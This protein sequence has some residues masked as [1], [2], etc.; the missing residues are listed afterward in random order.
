MSLRSISLSSVL[1]CTGFLSNE[2]SAGCKDLVL[3]MQDQG[4]KHSDRELTMVLSCHGGSYEFPEATTVNIFEWKHGNFCHAHRV[5]GNVKYWKGHIGAGAAWSWGTTVSDFAKSSETVNNFVELAAGSGAGDGGAGGAGG[6]ASFNN[7]NTCVNKVSANTLNIG[8]AS[9]IAKSNAKSR[10]YQSSLLSADDWQNVCINNNLVGYQK[11]AGHASNTT[12]NN[13]T[14][15]S[16]DQTLK[17]IRANNNNK[18]VCVSD[19]DSN[20][21]NELNQLAKG[22][23]VNVDACNGD[24][25][26][27][28]TL[29]G[30]DGGNGGNGGNG[31]SPVFGIESGETDSAGNIE[32]DFDSTTL[33]VNFAIEFGQIERYCSEKKE[34]V[35]F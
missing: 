27:D 19:A 30:G 6:N 8:K 20:V 9:G 22:S 31:Y 10:C 29:V 16:C 17:G 2:L 4:A 1:F 5:C 12:K 26:S 18:Y 13:F 15:A 7:K 23:H 28:V 32:T 3:R 34:E 35:C 21:Y 33:Q 24:V 25:A 14:K 11:K